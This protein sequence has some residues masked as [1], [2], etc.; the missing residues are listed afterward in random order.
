[1][2][3]TS[4]TVSPRTE[5]PLI[6][7]DTNVTYEVVSRHVREVTA[8]LRTDR[9]QLLFLAQSRQLSRF[10]LVHEC[11][12]LLLSAAHNITA[13]DVFP[14]PEALRPEDVAEWAAWSLST[15]L[16]ALERA[17]R[18]E[19]TKLS[20]DRRELIRLA[21]RLRHRLKTLFWTVAKRPP[22]IIYRQLPWFLIHGCHPPHIGMHPNSPG[23]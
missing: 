5:P 23:R 16:T 21:R 1:V 12:H 18:R 20:F 19:I 8:K 6:L 10:S 15:A 4:P 17:I 7:L 14:V 11:G 13:A 2:E 3:L 22:A 9:R